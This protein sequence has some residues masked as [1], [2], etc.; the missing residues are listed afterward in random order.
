MIW[1]EPESRRRRLF[2]AT[3][4][5][6]LCVAAYFAVA[7]RHRIFEHTPFNH[8][9]LLAEAWLDGRLDLAGPPPSYAQ[10]NDFARV[11]ERWFVAFPPFPAVL[12][13]PVVWLA[14]SAENV[15]DGQVFIWL[16]GVGPAVCFLALEK[17][18]RSGRS[19][20]SEWQN[21]VLSALLGLGTVYFFTAVQGTVWFAAH[22]VGLAL[23]AFYVL[24]AL[25]AERPILAG[26]M[27]GFGFLTRTPLIF[28]VPLF[29]F[30][31]L[32]VSLAPPD[33]EPQV[34]ERWYRRI[35]GLWR[36]LSIR[37]AAYLG[38]LFSLPILLCIGV[39]LW[40]NAMRFSGPFDFG[41]EHLTVAWAPRM[42]KWGLFS[43]H[44][45][46]RNLAVVLTGLPW[47]TRG[48]AAPFQIN[49]HGLAL[50]FTTPL[51]AWVLWPRRRHAL[52]MA[53]VATA[54]AVALPTLL[55]Q[56][57]GWIQFGYRFSND[58]AVFLFVLIA[59]SG[60]R[61]GAAFWA[62]ALFGVVVNAF[63]AITFD[64]GE[65]RKFYYED[66]SQKTFFQ[67]D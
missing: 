12:L 54:L 42:K 4:V 61:M 30:E 43:Y 67:P 58:Y 17:L 65:Y 64:R 44:Y 24:F 2:L 34:G 47:L 29:A 38:T 8:F 32:R 45:L 66:R 22:V 1:L 37:R 59:L 31:M 15:R 10:N 13:I 51:Y 41:Y 23:G 40:H 57:T 63:G 49:T 27:L 25:D 39:A 36:R 16:A 3:A 48:G 46:Q 7:P 28:A 20:R 53:F 6:A 60:R 26:L 33:G 21:A 52:Q 5:Y 55:Y 19:D 9:A 50:W 62:L 56:N 18:R 11:G 14:G 35:V